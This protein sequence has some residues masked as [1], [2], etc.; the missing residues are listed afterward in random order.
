MGLRLVLT[1]FQA[2][3][4]VRPYVNRPFYPHTL[5]KWDSIDATVGNVEARSSPE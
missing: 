4:S 2:P 3:Y 5:R 1:R